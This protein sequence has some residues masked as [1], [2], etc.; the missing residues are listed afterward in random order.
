[1][2]RTPFA[3]AAALALTAASCAAPVSEPEPTESVDQTE[4][5]VKCSPKLAYYPVR[6]RHNN[7]YDKTAGNSKLWSCDNAYSNTDYVKGDHLGN[8]IWAAE[9]T[10]VVATTSGK[11]TLVGYSSYSGNKVTIIDDC[12]WYH[13]YAHL[14]KLGPGISSSK[15]GTRVNA[16]AII[17]YVGKTGTA[18]NGVVHLHYSTYPDGNYNAGVDPYPYL[19]VVENDVCWV[20]G[21]CKPATEICNG[22]DDDCDGKIDEGEVCAPKDAGADA[23]SEAGV[24]AA[25]DAATDADPGEGDAEPPLSNPTPDDDATTEDSAGCSHSARTPSTGLFAVALAAFVSCAR[26]RSFTSRETSRAPAGASRTTRG[27]H[28]SRTGAL[29]WL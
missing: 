22:K 20:P 13:F 17:G 26:R 12:G 5:A 18:S 3:L 1:M 27:D 29:R 2:T 10:P 16:G 25:T 14:Q 21:T 11:L 24:D 23:A 6:G 19:K 8:D 4:Q 9:G 7:G 15:N 28:S